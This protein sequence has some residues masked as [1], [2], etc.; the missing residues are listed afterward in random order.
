[1][2]TTVKKKLRLSKSAL[3]EK[4][5]YEQQLTEE[6]KTLSPEDFKSRCPDQRDAMKTFVLAV[7]FNI[8]A[9]ALAVR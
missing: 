6:E 1:M 9:R 2:T 5:G 4:L 3:F 8:Q 7:I